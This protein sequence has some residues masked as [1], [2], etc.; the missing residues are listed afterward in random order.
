[1]VGR[2]RRNGDS[3]NL[4]SR[5]PFPGPTHEAES[6][7]SSV[8]TL[9]APQMDLR[10]KLLENYNAIILIIIKIQLFINYDHFASRSIP[11]E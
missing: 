8:L 7:W 9:F 1:M 4:D 5:R 3:S 11:G 10:T 2:M 6:P